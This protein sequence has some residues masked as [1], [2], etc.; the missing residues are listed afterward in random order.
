MRDENIRT[1]V[2]SASALFAGVSGFIIYFLVLYRNRQLKNKQEQEQLEFNFRQELLKA[3]IEIQEQ[4]LSHISN[5]IHDN[6]TQ[7]LFFVKLSLKT[8]A[9]ENEINKKKIDESNELIGQTIN[10]LRNLS[11]SLSFEHI[12]KLGLKKALEIEAERL[13][14]SGIFK[15]VFLVEGESYSLG[16]QRE[17]VL[18]RIYQEALNNALKHSG[19]NH[20]KINLQY[21]KD[22]F[23]LTVEDDGA[24]FLVDLTDKNGGLG[25]NNITNRAALI[26]AVANIESSQGNGCIIRVTLNP[27]EQ[28][29]DGHYSDRTG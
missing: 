12:T 10:D 22:L 27:F 17:L 20:F 25:L 21:Y 7:V 26:G 3:Q 6:I 8:I 15:P 11:K 19:A 2:L 14:N 18:F 13:D 5:E 1:L 9:T 29:I 28:Y 24:G 23:T 4:T 16:V